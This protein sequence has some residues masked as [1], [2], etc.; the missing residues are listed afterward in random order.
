MR[1]GYL[2]ILAVLM[3]TPS[4]VSADDIS[5]AATDL[6]DKVRACA[7]AQVAEEDLTP[8][9]L[10]VMEPMLDTMCEGLQA[11]VQDVEPGHPLHQPAIACM[12]SMEALSCDDMRNP[13][14]LQTAECD[15]YEKLAREYADAR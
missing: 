13:D 3:M 8:E 14:S 5:S 11:K 6:C 1:T 2:G 9:L 7:T 4:L 10:E 15:T 12:R